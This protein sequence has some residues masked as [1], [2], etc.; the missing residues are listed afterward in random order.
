VQDV[1]RK[2]QRA[3]RDRPLL[4]ITEMNVLLL[5]IVAEL[6]SRVPRKSIGETR[7]QLFERIDLPALKPLP[8][9]PFIY[10][11]E[12][13]FKV[14]PAYHVNVEGVDYSVPHRLI[15]SKVIVQATRLTIEVFHDGKP[16]AMHQ[17][18]WTRGS[19]VTDPTHMPA[20]H[21]QWRAKETADLEL[22][23]ETW[24][25]PVKTIMA[26]E[27]AKGYTGSAKQSQFDLVDHLARRFGREAFDQACARACALGNHTIA[28]VR[29]L[30]KAGRQSMPIRAVAKPV[31]RSNSKNVRGAAYYGGKK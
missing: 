8:E 10:F 26:A 4:T 22:W 16:V 18:C 1:Q 29:N 9:N 5:E 21:R 23:A 17:R 19:A 12:K 6:N 24:S 27:T 11:T 25:E 15:G 7:R 20:G 31:R 13:Q 14:P 2:L 30:L 28:H 3:L